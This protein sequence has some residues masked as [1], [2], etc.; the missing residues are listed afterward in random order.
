M[1]LTVTLDSR[2]LRAAVGRMRGPEVQKIMLRALEIRG[3]DVRKETVREFVRH[4]IGKGIFGHA[5]AGAWKQIKLEKGKVQAESVSVKIRL[6]GFPA[7]QETGGRIRP[8]VIKPK[9]KK[10]L[11]FPVAGGFGF[12]GDLVFTKLVNHPGANV[13]KHE[14]L[15]PAVQRALVAATE[16]I[17]RDLAAL[18]NRAA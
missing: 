12:G 8:H 7:L 6:T 18:W 14:A 2:A 9:N 11:A 15:K 5:D 13:P 3:N 4:G 1:K 17:R 10:Y 16:D